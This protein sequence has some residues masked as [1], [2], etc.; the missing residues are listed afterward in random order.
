MLLK[1]LVLIAIVAA[2]WFGFKAISRRNEAAKVDDRKKS[3]PEVEDMTACP[4]C[5]TY[6]TEGQGNCGRQGCPYK[7]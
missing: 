1:W 7:G 6:V 2:V 5:G 4:V 3:T